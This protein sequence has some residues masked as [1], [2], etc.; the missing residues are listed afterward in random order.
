MVPMLHGSQRPNSCSRTDKRLT[1][2]LSNFPVRRRLQ[3]SL[4]GLDLIGVGEDLIARVQQQL[5][6]LQQHE[7][8]LVD[9]EQENQWWRRR[10]LSNRRLQQQPFYVVDTSFDASIIPHHPDYLRI[11]ARTFNPTYVPFSILSTHIVLAVQGDLHYNSDTRQNEPRIECHH[12]WQESCEIGSPAGRI[13]ELPVRF[14]PRQSVEYEIEFGVSISWT[15]G[16]GYLADHKFNAKDVH[17]LLQVRPAVC[18]WRRNN[19]DTSK[20]IIR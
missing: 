1:C 7:Q 9:V 2:V 8:T 11:T 20:F 4:L 17:L 3:K 13:A 16:L 15:D 18:F 19:C 14:R 10:L 5:L 6:Q 12:N